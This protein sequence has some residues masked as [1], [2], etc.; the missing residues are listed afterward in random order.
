MQSSYGVN[1]L[2]LANQYAANTNCHWQREMYLNTQCLACLTIDHFKIVDPLDD[3]I[4]VDLA[5]I[6]LHSFYWVDNQHVLFLLFACVLKSLVCFKSI[7]EWNKT[8][9]ANNLR[10]YSFPKMHLVLF[11]VS[12]QKS[13]NRRLTVQV[14]LCWYLH[15][16]FDLALNLYCCSSQQSF[17][18]LKIEDHLKK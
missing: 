11:C 1:R 6:R 5:I 10:L 2:L 12:E 16:Y 15:Y 8:D 9:L 17:V 13:L 4:A 3:S 14:L 18:C 7:F